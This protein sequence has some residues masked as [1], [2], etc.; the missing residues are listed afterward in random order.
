M[1]QVGGILAKKKFVRREG[2][3][4]DPVWEEAVEFGEYVGL[5]PVFVMKLFKLYG[6]HRVLELRSN[7]R[8]MP[9]DI[10]KGKEGLVIWLLK[11]GKQEVKTINL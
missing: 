10:T 1:Q 8:D 9:Y 7:L 2:R 4:I 11:K 6:K 3:E 5:K